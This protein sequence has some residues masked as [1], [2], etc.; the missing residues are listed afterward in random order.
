MSWNSPTAS[1]RDKPSK[2]GQVDYLLT[3][4]RSRTPQVSE[5]RVWDWVRGT[6]A[7]ASFGP[8]T[9]GQVADKIDQLKKLPFAGKAEQAQPNSEP[10]PDVPEGR[11]AVTGTG[12]D[13]LDT[14][15]R[16]YKVSYPTRGRDAGRLRVM[17]G[18]GGAN[19][20]DQHGNPR[21]VW[22][23]V[24]NRKQVRRILERV[25]QTG[26]E[27]AMRT[28]GIKLRHCGRCG[29][30]LTVPESRRTGFGP[31]CRHVLGIKV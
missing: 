11:Y 25:E 18:R 19:G 1:W 4:T 24:W 10:M 9:R 26:L 8:A 27:D 13:A 15:L 5:D 23:K 20:N 21:I 7:S 28:F 12:H 14:R 6:G 16:F 30:S 29:K 2:P 31:D 3:L 17:E 22:T